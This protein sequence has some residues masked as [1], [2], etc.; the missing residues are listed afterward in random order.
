M[1]SYKNLSGNSGVVAYEIDAQSIKVQ[2]NDPKSSI[3][4]YTYQSAAATTLRK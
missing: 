2:F 1:N 3:Y 4:L